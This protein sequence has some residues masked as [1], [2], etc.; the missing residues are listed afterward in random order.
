MDNKEE[1][2]FPYN[3][4]NKILSEDNLQNLLKTYDTDQ[5]YDINYYRRAFIHKSY[6]TRKNENYETGNTNCPENC[7]YLQ[8][9]S[10]E[11]LEYL[12]DSI[13]NSSIA[14]YVFERY[15]DENEGFL[16]VIRTKLVNGKMLANLAKKIGLSEYLVIS[17][18]IDENDGRNNKNVLEDAFE[19][20]IGA[21]YLDH[22]E[23]NENGFNI[24]RNWIIN[25]I[26]TFVDFSELI[27]KNENYKDVLIKYCQHTHQFIPKF[28]E[29]DV[30]ERNGKK[31]HSVVVKN[32]AGD[33]LGI[34]KDIN[35]K[36]A[37]INASKHALDFYG[38]F[39]YNS[40]QQ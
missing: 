40:L 19:A 39:Q 22:E 25:V 31:I 15:P 1:E 7:M 10:N 16:T 21:I 32:D 30:M 28:Y 6:V 2:I 36:T 27:H 23:K 8:E 34:G 37:E 29:I 24:A 17:K 33:I 4:N 14:S 35:R 13:L 5:Y 12:G 18:Q 26:E 38:Y 3:E 9:L 20:F 11:R